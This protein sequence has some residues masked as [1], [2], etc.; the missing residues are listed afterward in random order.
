MPRHRIEDVAT[1][2]GWD[3]EEWDVLATAENRT[4]ASCLLTCDRTRNLWQLEAFY[5]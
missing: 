5:D 4:T 3:A 2:E 1:P